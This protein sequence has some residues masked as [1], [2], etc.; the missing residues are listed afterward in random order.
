MI[1]GASIVGE[2]LYH[3]CKE[4]GIEVEC[5]CDNDTRKTRT[6]FCGLDVVHPSKVRKGAEFIIASTYIMDIIAQLKLLGQ[7][8][9]QD[10][11]V[12]LKDFNIYK[13][14]YSAPISYVEYMVNACIM[15]HSNYLDTGK[16]FLRS[17]DIVVTERCSLKCRDC[18]NLMQYYKHPKNYDTAELLSSIDK[19]CSIVDEINEMR[20][21]GGEVFM[22]R[23]WYKI[24]NKL[25]A[26]SK[27]KKILVYSNGTMIP[28]DLDK[29][30]KEKSLFIITDYGPLSRKINE[31]IKTL[32][33]YGI[34]Y[35]SFKA[36]GW[37]NS[38]EIRKHGRTIEEQKEIFR[39]CCAKNF[40][41]L[42]DGKIYRCPFSAHLNRLNITSGDFVDLSDKMK[43]R[44]FVM[45]LEYLDS[46]E[47]CNGRSWGDP[48]ITPAV[49]IKKPL[50]YKGNYGELSYKRR[51]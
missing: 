47:F 6:K 20:V 26:Q 46:C 17:V 34:S 2:V 18:C 39:K 14:Q 22:N 7:T 27:V 10:C 41:T 38:A 33:K 32:E 44:N 1:F 5:F 43:I 50:E 51:Y 31:I 25:A 36:D 30:K 40:V 8:K 37:T 42:S 49:Q 21:I 23:E 12:L 19:L 4:A 45:G 29:M 13:Y 24:V 28:N 9:W 15:C 48:N 35:Y 11:T 16:L 3:A